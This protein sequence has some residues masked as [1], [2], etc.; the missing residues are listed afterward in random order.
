MYV[1]MT[2][3]REHLY[4]TNMRSIFQFGK[5]EQCKPAAWFSQLSQR[6]DICQVCGMPLN[7]MQPG[8]RAVIPGNAWQSKQA[9]KQA[10]LQEFKGCNR[11]LQ[12]WPSLLDA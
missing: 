4:L 2:R 5:E 10:I 8:H 7:R 9:S 1:A 11:R 3:A 6:P 12:T